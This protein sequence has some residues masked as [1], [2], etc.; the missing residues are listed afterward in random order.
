[1]V[2]IVARRDG[3]ESR[4]A[5]DEIRRR[6]VTVGQ[7]YNPVY[8]ADDQR[9]I[10]LGVYVRSVADQI[11]AG[12]GR[13]D[14][15]ARTEFAPMP[16]D[17]DT[18]LPVGLIA[19]ELVTNAA[20]HGFRDGRSGEIVI[21]LEPEGEAAT[22]TIED[23]GVGLEGEPEEGTGLRLVNAMAPQV[24]GRINV[25]A[26]PEGGTRFV[27]VFRTVRRRTGPLAS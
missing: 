7:A 6:I 20:R 11:I 5:F 10:D 12:T 1:M 21:R 25:E 4:A 23:D 2:G 15:T 9:S 14:I 17:I 24:D 8:S 18:A 22:L 26:R 16:V 19:H 13:R 27:L 3:R